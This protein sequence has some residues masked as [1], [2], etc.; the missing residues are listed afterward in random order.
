MG[1]AFKVVRHSKDETDL[2]H[3]Y[4]FKPIDRLTPI[5]ATANW[6]GFTPLGSIAR[7]FNWNSSILKKAVEECN[8][9]NQIA[10]VNQV[11]PLLFLVPKTRGLGQTNFLINDLLNALEE[12]NTKI[13]N[14]TH[15]GFVQ[16]KLPRDEV[17]SI[18]VEMIN[19]DQKKTCIEK[20][21]IDID[22]RVENELKSIYI[23]LMNIE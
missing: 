23:N 3:M 1:I 4:W 21:I 9:K 12:T 8:N 10:V 6:D 13:I 18:L 20:I 19:R 16:N 11:T 14:F 2:G 22:A 17:K 15:F 7:E 5:S